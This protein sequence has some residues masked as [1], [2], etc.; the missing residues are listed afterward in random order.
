MLN[1]DDRY[2]AEF[3]DFDDED[4][5]KDKY[6]TFRL[7]PEEYGVEIR[8]VTEIIGIQKITEVPDVDTYVKGVINLR[9]KIIPVIDVRLRFHLPP[10]EYGDRTCIVVVD[11]DSSPVGLIVDEVSEVVNIPE[12]NIS[13][14][15]KTSKNADGKYVQGIGKVGDSVKIILNIQQMLNEEQLEQL[16]EISMA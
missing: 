11:V 7:H 12:A 8:F 3:E 1:R 13:A 9:G 15:P 14:P 16:S 2:E 5:Q 4:T 6:L 10:R